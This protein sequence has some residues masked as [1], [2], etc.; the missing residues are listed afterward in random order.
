VAA[1]LARP[2]HPAVPRLAGPLALAA[3]AAV[4]TAPAAA[5]AQWGDEDEA[6]APAR[7]PRL[8]FTLVGGEAFA[9]NTDAAVSGGV[10][11]GEVAYAFD[12]IEVGV[13]AQAYRI[14]ATPSRAWSPV[15]L[16][17]LTERF[18]TRRGIEASF[19]F[20]FGAG[21]LTHWTAWYQVALGARLSLSSSLFLAGELSFEQYDLLRLA[22]GLGVRF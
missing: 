10:A 1:Q 2:Y 18:E 16:L 19:T 12:A 22:A 5:R 15:T 14:R 21:E 4:S 11:G 13:L 8:S 7:R 17:R 3:I 20:G 9:L 6:Y